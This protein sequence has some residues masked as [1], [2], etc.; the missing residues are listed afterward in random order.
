MKFQ[1]F[2]LRKFW[3]R[4]IVKYLKNC[5]GCFHSGK[6]G[7]E[8]KYVKLF[9]DSQYRKFQELIYENDIDM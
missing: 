2:K 6:Y 3:H 1:L 9:T 5:G 4:L 7:K 8:G